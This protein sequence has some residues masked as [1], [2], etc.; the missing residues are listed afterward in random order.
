MPQ[1]IICENLYSGTL[2]VTPVLIRIHTI[3][4]YLNDFQQ[5]FSSL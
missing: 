2:H 5:V 4:S 1:K 3:P